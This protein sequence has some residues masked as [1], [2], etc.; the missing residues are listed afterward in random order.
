MGNA[1]F[2]YESAAMNHLLYDIQS[3]TLLQSNLGPFFF[4]T[5]LQVSLRLLGISWCSALLRSHHSVW[6]LTGPLQNLKSFIFR[7]W[8]GVP[9]IIDVVSDPASTKILLLDRWFHICLLNPEYSSS[10]EVM[11]V[12][13]R[14]LS[15]VAVKKTQILATPPPH[16]TRSMKFTSEVPCLG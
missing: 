6:T 9:Q 11:A 7:R 12:T 15:H 14:C 3:L 13:A 10:E 4:T 8:G 1:K 2:S 5:F 16:L